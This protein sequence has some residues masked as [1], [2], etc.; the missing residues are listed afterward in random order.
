VWGPLSAFLFL[1]FSLEPLLT[2][3]LACA[4]HAGSRRVQQEKGPTPQLEPLE[5][6]EDPTE[7]LL[8]TINISEK[9]GQSASC[10]TLVTSFALEDWLWCGSA[11]RIVAIDISRMLEDL[12]SSP[13]LSSWPVDRARRQP[14]HEGSNLRS[15]TLTPSQ[16]S[17]ATPIPIP[18]ARG[19]VAAEP[20]LTQM[21]R[22]RPFTAKSQEDRLPDPPG[23]SRGKDIHDPAVVGHTSEGLIF[24]LIA[25][26]DCVWSAS[27]RDHVICAWDKVDLGVCL[28]TVD[29]A[30]LVDTVCGAL[31]QLPSCAGVGGERERGL[32][33]LGMLMHGDLW[34]GGLA[35]VAI[36]VLCDR[37]GFCGHGQAPLVW[38]ER[39]PPRG[40]ESGN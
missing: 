38:D 11:G 32:G 36:A 7:G 15:S 12:Q 21:Q 37:H 16:H 20:T 22:L 10:L 30:S 6:L 31:P 8:L 14:N 18:M 9:A 13:V 3:G 27:R 39:R 40:R 23:R 24:R 5:S 25:V 2:P 19:V 26:G 34:C 1:W 17:H 29:V 4:A 28:Q 35:G 33:T